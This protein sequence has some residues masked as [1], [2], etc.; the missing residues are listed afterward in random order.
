MFCYISKN[1]QGQPLI[2]IETVVS[3]ISGTTTQKGLKIDCIVDNN[4]YETGRKISD[5][6]L[7]QVNPI[8]LKTDA[9]ENKGVDVKV[10]LPSIRTWKMPSKRLLTGK[11]MAILKK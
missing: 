8:T 9:Y 1:W 11:H 5:E 3:L 6:E 4:I 2:D 7:A 10:R